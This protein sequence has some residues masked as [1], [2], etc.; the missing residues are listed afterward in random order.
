MVMHYSEVHII[1]ALLGIVVDAYA[2]FGIAVVKG[3]NLFLMPYLE[4]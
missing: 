4:Y 2:L 1:Y 3:I